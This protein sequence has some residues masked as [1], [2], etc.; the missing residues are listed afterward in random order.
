MPWDEGLRRLTPPL[1]LPYGGR[2]PKATF[3][4][5]AERLDRRQVRPVHLDAERSAESRL[6]HHDPGLDRLKLRGA[7]DARHV[8][9]RHDGIPDV[10]GGSD[11]VAPLAVG[12][13]A[14]FLDELAHLVTI[15]K[16]CAEKFSKFLSGRQKSGSF[17][18]LG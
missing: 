13:A 16:L 3:E 15:W 12:A 10:L 5:K 4:F 18:L 17:Q 8:R 14:A 1:G 9:R 7:G 11:L 2:V 6:E